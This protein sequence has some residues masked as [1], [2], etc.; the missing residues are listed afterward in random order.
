MDRVKLEKQDQ[1]NH[2]NLVGDR[3]SQRPTQHTEATTQCRFLPPSDNPSRQQPVP[4]SRKP[5]NHTGMP[6]GL[7]SGLEQLSGLDLSSVR[8]HYNSPRPRELGAHAY[9]R[10]SDIHLASGQERHLPHEGWH[11]VQQMQ[12]RVQASV[13]MKSGLNVNDDPGLEQEADIMGHRALTTGSRSQPAGLLASP[14]TET[15]TIYQLVRDIDLTPSRDAS[16]PTFKTL[17]TEQRDFA[18]YRFHRFNWP[19]LAE[20]LYARIAAIKEQIDDDDDMANVENFE[21]RL[22]TAVTRGNALVDDFDTAEMDTRRRSRSRSRSEFALFEERGSPPARRRSRSRS[23]DRGRGR[24]RER[25]RVSSMGLDSSPPRA[26]F[27]RGRSPVRTYKKETIMLKMQSVWGSVFDIEKVL[28]QYFPPTS[29][30]GFSAKGRANHIETI[31]NYAKGYVADDTWLGGRTIYKR[32]SKSLPEFASKPVIW[33]RADNYDLSPREKTGALAELE[34]DGIRRGLSPSLRIPYKGT[35][36][37]KSRDGGQAANMGK[38]NATAYAMLSNI[39]GWDTKKWEWLHVRASSLGGATNGTNLVVGTR[40]AN[41]HMM[42]FEANIKHIATAI[43]RSPVY[44]RIEADYDFGGVDQHARHKVSSISLS[45]RIFTKAA[46]TTVSY[47]K[48]FSFN[49]LM[50]T[51]SI[52]KDEVGI[53]EDTL[54]AERE[55]L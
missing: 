23:R 25:S 32:R 26:D 27:R 12:G 17:I 47:Q 50:T 28:N 2:G 6:T 30:G 37:R 42:P 40:D 29:G 43:G 33:G 53:L 20:G 39:A 18:G 15:G 16:A 48:T 7:K 13:Q 35:P 4:D 44:D 51:S 11:A 10:G 5:T 41:T 36:T 21:S 14:N 38:T 52:S 46:P 54:K 3:L 55:S 22:D 8:V 45:W 1:P 49:P 31:N 9:C 34:E 19:G 24:S